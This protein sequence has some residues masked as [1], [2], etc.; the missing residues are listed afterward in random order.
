MI[1]T[2]HIAVC[3]KPIEGNFASNAV[4]HGVAGINVDGA[5]IPANGEKTGGNGYIGLAE[6]KGWNANN[7]PYKREQEQS[8][9]QGRWPANVITDGSQEVKAEF[10][11]THGAGHARDGS[12]AIVSDNYN[13][14]SYE[15]GQNKRMRRLGDSGS[16][17]RFFKECQADDD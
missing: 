2:V 9:T 14:T 6:S 8:T 11:E 13:A 15:T 3:M 1:D 4:A 7:M 10:P 12:K 17:A 5:R 16:V